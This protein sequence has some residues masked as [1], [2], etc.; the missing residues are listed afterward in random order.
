MSNQ[1]NGTGN[2]GMPPILKTVSVK[3]EQRKVL[4]LRVLFDAYKSDG[5]D[6]YVQ[7]D[8]A[9]FWKDVVVWGDRGE[10][11]ASHLVKGARVHVTGTVRGEKW[12]DKTTGEDRYS[13]S[14]QADDVFLSFVRVEAVTYRQ[15]KEGDGQNAGASEN[16]AQ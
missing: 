7:D 4:E 2:I 16:H 14:V 11:A 15:P 12:K 6:G 3:G 13:D 1:F 8:A 9:S 5:N 10:R